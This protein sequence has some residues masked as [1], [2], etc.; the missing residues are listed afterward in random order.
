M[1]VTAQ[2]WELTSGRGANSEASEAI[3]TMHTHAY[4][5]AIGQTSGIPSAA[6]APTSTPQ[7]VNTSLLHD[8]LESGGHRP[9]QQQQQ[10]PAPEDV[11]RARFWDKQ[12]A[13][14]NLSML[15]EITTMQV[16]IMSRGESGLGKTVC[17]NQHHV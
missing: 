17:L 15:P 16:N 12:I 8:L 13:D 11:T 6:N 9:Q 7:S 2:D 3:T 14:G 1:C 4:P 10:Q 5:L